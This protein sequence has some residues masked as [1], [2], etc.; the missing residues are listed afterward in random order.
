MSPDNS[1][2]IRAL[3]MLLMMDATILVLLGAAFIFAPQQIEAAF[4]FP[5]LPTG[6]N[7]LIGMW[8]CALATMGFG[9]AVAA[10]DPVRHAVWVG[11]GVARGV[12]E[13]AVG[14]WCFAR[15]FVTWQQSGFGI[16][17]AAFMAV[18]YLALYPR[19]SREAGW[20]LPL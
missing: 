20:R 5:P 15:G 4:H 19:N 6:V 16:L 10:M 11:V 9:Y 13:A 18:G 7:F 14:W 3:R 2:R 8:G 12:L 1:P 17:L